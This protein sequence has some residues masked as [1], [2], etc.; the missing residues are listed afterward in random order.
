MFSQMTDQVFD[1]PA[2]PGGQFQRFQF[3]SE[4]TEMLHGSRIRWGG[5][6]RKLLRLFYS[7]DLPGLGPK[8][9]HSSQGKRPQYIGPVVFLHERGSALVFQNDFF[10]CGGLIDTL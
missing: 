8:Q 4:L 7:M 9:N 6:K 2:V 10:D 3:G 1:G 5:V